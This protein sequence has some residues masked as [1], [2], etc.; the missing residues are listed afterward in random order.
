[1]RYTIK[2]SALCVEVD[3]MGAQLMSVKGTDGVERLWQGDPD[4]WKG[5]A[6]ILFPLVGRLKDEQYT[7]NGQTYQIPIHGFG[8]RLPWTLCEQT[9]DAL[10]FVLRDD[11]Q[12]RAQY[13][14]AFE[15]FVRYALNGDAVVKTHTVRNRS[16]DTM[17]YEIGGHDGFRTTLEAGECMAD[18]Y[19]EFPGVSSL[20]ACTND[21]NLMLT[22]EKRTVP[23]E[24]GRLYLKPGLFAL[25]AIILEQP[26]CHT[27]TLASEKS[28]RR[29]TVSFADYDYVAIWSRPR[30]TDND[31]V[32]IEPWSSLPDAN[33]IGT[34]LSEK[35]GV[36][37]LAPGA[38]ESLVYTM[39][40]E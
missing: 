32:C 39:R 1:M 38:E 13:P 9:E 18:S 14:Y 5:R 15:C 3:D 30:D 8:Q 11:E 40:F 27:L 7:L 28:S 21:E 35:I 29:V 33:Y 37:S 10:T 2:N 6:P 4:I 17:Y 26:P 19:I 23:L 12:T 25:D 36:R 24:N 20:S 16:M 22:R 34:A 31:Y